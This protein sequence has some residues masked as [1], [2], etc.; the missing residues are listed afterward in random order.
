MNILAVVTGE[1]VLNVDSN[2]NY[3]MVAADTEQQCSYAYVTF[4]SEQQADKNAHLI[5]GV[6]IEGNNLRASLHTGEIRRQVPDSA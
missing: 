6:K 3:T 4:A 1:S 5:Q 2:H